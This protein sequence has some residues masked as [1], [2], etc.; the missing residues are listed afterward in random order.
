MRLGFLAQ[1]AIL[2]TTA[3]LHGVGGLLLGAPSG[4]WWAGVGISAALLAFGLIGLV[5]EQREAR[6]AEAVRGGTRQVATR[7]NA[8]EARRSPR[9]A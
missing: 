9:A 3:R 6:R 8:A 2:S 4:W 1:A 5:R 7:G